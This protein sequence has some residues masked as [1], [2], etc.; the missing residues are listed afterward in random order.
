MA[1]P[2]ATDV[3]RVSTRESTETK[4]FSKTS[5]FFVLLA[6]VIGILVASYIMDGFGAEAAWRFITYAS[7]GYMIS[8]GLAKAGSREPYRTDDRT[9]LT[10]R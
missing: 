4:A 9:G 5:E 8:R 3:S 6:T 2:A 7:I 10:D 1:T